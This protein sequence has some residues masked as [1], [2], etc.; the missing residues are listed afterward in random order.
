MAEKVL[1]K[2]NEAIGEAAVIAGCRYY[3]GYPITPQSELIE[4][5]AKRLPQVNGV[6]LQAESEVAAIN[7]VYGAAGAGARVMT[8]S[9]SPGVSL[10]QEG[11][12]YIAAGELPCVI[13]NIMRGGPGLGGIQ[14][15]QA[16]Y[17][18][19]TKGGG[20]G[21]YHCIVVAPNSVQEMAELTVL[22][23]NLADQYRNPVMLLGDGALGQMME[24]VDFH[25][26]P[27]IPVEKP[28]ATTGMGER[29]K[30]NIIDT[31]RLNPEALEAV[32]DALQKK[33]ALLQEQEV[34][35]E[36][37]FTEDAELVL[38][39]Y[40]ISSRVAYSAMEMARAQGYKVGLF[41][42]ITLWPFPKA[43]LLK[44]VDKAAAV[45][46]IELSA[47]QMVEDVSLA[48]RCS[49]PV[50]FYGRTGGMMM[51][52]QD[53]YQQIVKIFETKGGK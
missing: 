39:A 18:Q 8:S 53:V 46:T 50:H 14:P 19:A 22:A 16:D 35:W 49:R 29:D 48:I 26:L 5:M 30:P 38:V 44:A 20:H 1:M 17:F 10:K 34:R 31:L 28:W 11:I 21:D 51:S 33:Y 45:L 7:M 52:P 32:N 25:N 37:T 6:F 12:S 24:P 3:F 9:S 23:F 43:A 27:V 36:E 2:G 13:V 40:G 15:G 41:R 47:G 42:P 4:Y